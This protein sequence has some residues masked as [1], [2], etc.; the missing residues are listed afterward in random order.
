MLPLIASSAGISQGP[1]DRH[2]LNKR[3]QEHEDRAPS[4]PRPLP[5]TLQRSVYAIVSLFGPS[6]QD[7]FLRGLFEFV[8]RRL[9]PWDYGESS[10]EQAK[11]QAALQALGDRHYPNCLEVGCSEGVFTRL[12][13]G[14]VRIGQITALDI[15]PRALRAARERCEGLGSISFVEGG[16]ISAELTGPY[17]L[18]FCAEI[19]YYLG[20][21]RRK[22]AVRLADTLRTGG[23]LIL[24][25]P[26]P[27]AGR[28]HDA[29]MACDKR[30][31]L[32][33]RTT[34][35]HELRPYEVMT[36]ELGA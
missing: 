17:D 9:A 35:R 22:L 5:D 30:Y 2:D 34:V 26:W 24:V 7:R 18:A 3:A 33:T 29:F 16:A 12:L 23:R 36:L 28:L 20:F 1:G 13:A 6:A 32:L 8:H 11:Y 4:P 15:S 25:H 19:L 31:Q 27:E 21:S 14:D 10:Y